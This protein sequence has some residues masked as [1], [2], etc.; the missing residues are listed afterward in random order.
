[1][2]KNKQEAIAFLLAMLEYPDVYTRQGAVRGLSRHLSPKIQR[3][4]EVV[5]RD[6]PHPLVRDTA[7]EVLE[8]AQ[9]A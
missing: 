2:K 7:N 6:D 1:M 3:R 4:L 5:A 9:K 8:D